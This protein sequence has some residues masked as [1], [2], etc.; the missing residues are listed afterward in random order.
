MAN[1]AGI[2][3]RIVAL[4]PWPSEVNTDQRDKL[5]ADIAQLAED[6]AETVVDDVK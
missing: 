6:T 5:L 3:N 2:L 1:L 4:I